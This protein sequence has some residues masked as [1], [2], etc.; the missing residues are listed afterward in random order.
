LKGIL[1]RVPAPE[2][3]YRVDQLTWDDTLSYRYPCL[4]EYNPD[5]DGPL[6]LRGLYVTGPIGK[7]ATWK[8]IY[9]DDASFFSSVIDRFHLDRH[10]AD[11][12]LYAI[13]RTPDRK[14]LRYPTE[15]AV[16]EALLKI[17]L[18]GPIV[19]VDE[20]HTMTGYDS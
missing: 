17:G 6:L 20:Q 4:P 12:I 13:S 8:V 18:V 7:K 2:V 11:E 3:S 9:V 15:E 10:R 19:D 5:R 1:A 14:I 16:A